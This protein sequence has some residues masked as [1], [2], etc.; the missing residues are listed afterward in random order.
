MA[1]TTAAISASGTSGWRLFSRRKRLHR[2]PTAR[3]AGVRGEAVA[4][5]LIEHAGERRASYGELAARAG[6][7]NAARAVGTVMANNEVPIIIPCHR[8][9][10]SGGAI[11]A[12]GWGVS[13][14]IW[15]LE[16]EGAI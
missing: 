14:K 16:H 12:Y 9:I 2:K 5:T 15:L 3:W 1:P 7:P 11:G 8:I 6:S 10:K 13:K 4:R